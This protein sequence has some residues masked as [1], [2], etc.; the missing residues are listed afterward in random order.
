MTDARQCPN[1]GMTAVRF[2]K[3]RCGPC[4]QY[5]YVNGVERPLT[6]I[7]QME[8]RDPRRPEERDPMDSHPVDTRIERAKAKVK[9]LGLGSNRR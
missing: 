3:S 2:V 8:I 1:C 7:R 4:Y 5:R 9:A 6:L